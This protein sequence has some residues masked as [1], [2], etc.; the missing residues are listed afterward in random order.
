MGNE[1]SKI[2]AGIVIARRAQAIASFDIK[3]L[4]IVL[5]KCED[6]NDRTY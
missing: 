3:A 2:V 4:E 1:E 6:T 5:P